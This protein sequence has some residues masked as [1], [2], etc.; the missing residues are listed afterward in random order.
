MQS[1]IALYQGLLPNGAL[2]HYVH[3]IV[4]ARCI[5]AAVMAPREARISRGLLVEGP[6]SGIADGPW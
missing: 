6:R 3:A 2:K 4:R 1:S 5:T